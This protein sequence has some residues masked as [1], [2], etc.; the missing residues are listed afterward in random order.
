MERLAD[1]LPMPWSG[2]RLAQ[3]KV[4]VVFSTGYFTT[5]VHRDPNA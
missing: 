2:N 3:A 5:Y 4:V 1:L